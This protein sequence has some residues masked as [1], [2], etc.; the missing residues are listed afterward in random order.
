M[1]DSNITEMIPLGKFICEYK[2]HNV[3]NKYRPVAVG[4]DDYGNVCILG[5]GYNCYYLNQRNAK[6]ELFQSLNKYYLSQI[7]K[8]SAVKKN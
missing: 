1:K 2:E 3:E 6:L 8:F 7:L 4:K 5:D